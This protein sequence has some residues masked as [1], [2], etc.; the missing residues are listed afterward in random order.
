MKLSKNVW[1]FKVNVKTGKVELSIPKADEIT[2]NMIF[3]A[4]FGASHFIASQHKVLEEM[5]KR[6]HRQI[7]QLR[8]KAK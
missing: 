3:W 7:A 6:A 5:M 8:A 4:I 1:G 2:V